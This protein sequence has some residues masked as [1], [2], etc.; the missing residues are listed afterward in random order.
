MKHADKKVVT[1]NVTNRCNLN[2]S[3]CMASAGEEQG[4]PFSIPLKFA[5]AGIEDAV[6]GI[7]T[8]FKANSLRFFAPGEPT[9]DMRVIKSCVTF[10]K[11]LT[12]EI[13]VEIQT[14]GLFG[15]QDDVNWIANNVDMVW[16]SL[17]GPAEVNDKTRPDQN[18]VGR[19]AEIEENLKFIQ[20]RTNVGVRATV[21]EDLID[22]QTVIVQHYHDIGVKYL[23]V[24][25][26]IRPIKRGDCGLVP[27]NESSQMRFAKGFV[28]AYPLADS[29]GIEFT[30]SM[31]FNFDEPTEISCRS[32][33]PMP[34]LNPDG[35]VS[36][37]DM[38]MYADTKEELKQFLYG[39]WNSET[40]KIE[41]DMD[42]IAHL[43]THR[44]EMLPK[45]NSCVIGKFC[46][47][48]CVG[49]IAYQTSELNGVL[50]EICAATIYMA[51][52]IPLGQNKYTRTHP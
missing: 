35:S 16:F 30:N 42:K 41:Y 46:A 32:C 36:S 23:A 40:S 29:F 39:K 34:Q 2:C 5:F 18:G 47:G 52:Y 6:H 9:Q 43:Q 25:P 14:N 37:C 38:A 15:N 28:R 50:A 7:P 13:A 51:Q 21:T 11:N 3:Y 33:V 4:N 17:D 20:S 45:C 8:G 49:R 19:T 1:V 10:A 24:N 26:V 22:N 48:G 31:T 12:P 44:L 27:V